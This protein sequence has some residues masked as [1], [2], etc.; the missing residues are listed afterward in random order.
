MSNKS[1]S[2]LLTQADIDLFDVYSS[3][4]LVHETNLNDSLFLQNSE[5]KYHSDKE[6]IQNPKTK[7]YEQI[8]TYFSYMLPAPPCKIV[9][10]NYFYLN[11]PY[12]YWQIYTVFLSKFQAK[13]KV[14]NF[15][16]R[17]SNKYFNFLVELSLILTPLLLI[18]FLLK[19]WWLLILL[20]IV[21]MKWKDLRVVSLTP[22]ARQRRVDGFRP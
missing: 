3:F 14:N 18:F 10:N 12:Q 20:I 5:V 21:L 8:P 15:Y 13:F 11:L 2:G 19:F 16:K 17:S 22:K 4:G 6:F 7:K 1:F 9:D